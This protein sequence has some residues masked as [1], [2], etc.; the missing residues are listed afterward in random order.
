MKNVYFHRPLSFVVTPKTRVKSASFRFVMVQIILMILLVAA[1]TYGLLGLAVGLRHDGVAVL[2][3][4]FWATYDLLLLS[5][6]IRAL[7]FVN[8]EDKTAEGLNRLGLPTQQRV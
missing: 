7:L 3:N 6:V 5:V 2:A 4:V 8:G 1:V